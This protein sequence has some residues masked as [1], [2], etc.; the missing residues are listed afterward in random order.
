MGEVEKE[1]NFSKH[2]LFHGSLAFSTLSKK[3][4]I[5]INQ[6]DIFPFPWE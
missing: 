6:K 4:A 5:H 3:V 2:F 1:R